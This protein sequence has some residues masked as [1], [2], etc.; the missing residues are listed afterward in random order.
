MD[1]LKKRTIQGVIWSGIEKLS[2]QG[3]L[4]VINIIIARILLPSDFGTVALM[5]VFLAICQ[6]FIDSGFGLAL[7]RKK[8]CTEEDFST[9]LI[10][11]IITATISYIILW[12]A[13]P[14]IAKFYNLPTLTTIARVVSLNIV[15]NALSNVPNAK[16]SIL[17]DFRS[18]AL[19]TLATVLIS[20]SIGLWMA[21]H[22]FGVW[23]LVYQTLIGNCA[24]TF[25]LYASTKWFPKLRFS[26]KSFYELFSFGSK[27][28]ISGIIGNIY[29]HLS[30]ILIGKVYST[31]SL[32]LY[33]KANTFANLPST[34]ITGVILNVTYPALAKIQ[35]DEK[36]LINAYRQLLKI[37]TFAIFPLMIGLSAVAKPLVI[38][39]LGEKWEGMIPLL[40]IL[41][42]AMMWDPINGVNM[43]LLQVKGY[44]N[45]FLKVD[46]YKK[47][48]GATAL[49]ITIPIGLEAICYGLL[50][51]A[52]INRPINTYYSYRLYK[53]GFKEQLKDIFPNLIHAL[54]L[55]GIVSATMWFIDGMLAKLI[56]GIITGA[57]YY[58]IYGYLHYSKEFSSLIK[59]I[60]NR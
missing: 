19:I 21:Y 10:F 3:I 27:M 9:V 51:V 38:F 25:F 5:N 42:F 15:V 26:K 30:S 47:I 2:S 11:S 36:R 6:T 32:G 60:K 22:G 1:S 7:M 46:T 55:G 45:I 54:I 37:S 28:L 13:A 14:W 12:I 16:L 49:C 58:T 57:T 17:L 18:K 52:L 33:G 39:A 34:Q 24:R 41:S 56:I 59:A 4:F 53:Y 44:S 8:E 35:D 31:T 29:N 23:T 43:N 40:Q 50:A 48:I 20:G